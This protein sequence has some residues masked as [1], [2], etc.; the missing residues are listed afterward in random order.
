M[1]VR[2]KGLVDN[3]EQV[4]NVFIGKSASASIYFFNYIIVQGIIPVDL[5]GVKQVKLESVSYSDDSFILTADGVSVK[6]K[7][8]GGS[9]INTT[10]AISGFADSDNMYI[11]AQ[12]YIISKENWNSYLKD[13]QIVFSCPMDITVYDT[14]GEIMQEKTVE[15]SL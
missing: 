9:R 1:T 10:K 8:T 11:D 13:K 5:T 6:D 4:A 15:V 12:T 7:I 14:A 2:P 3:V